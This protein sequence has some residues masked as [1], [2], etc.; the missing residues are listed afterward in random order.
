MEGDLVNAS[1]AR[2]RGS[3]A[4]WDVY[5]PSN[6]LGASTIPAAIGVIVLAAGAAFLYQRIT[7]WMPLIYAN[8]LIAAGLGA[9]IGGL[10]SEAFL[11]THGRSPSMASGLAVAAAVVAFVASFFAG[12]SFLR[13]EIAEGMRELKGKAALEGAV[14]ADDA[15]I[16]AAIQQVGVQDFIEERVESGWTLGR[17][18]SGV[19]ISGV[20][21]WCVWLAELVLIA[22]AA[23]GLAR[24][25][26]D[27][28]YCEDCGRFCTVRH[29]ATLRHM[30]PRAVDDALF[31]ASIDALLAVPSDDRRAPPVEVEAHV[32]RKS[33]PAWL[34]VSTLGRPSERGGKP[35]KLPLLEHVGVPSAVLARVVERA[36]QKAE[37]GG[38]PQAPVRSRRPKPPDV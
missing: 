35:E 8:F 11:R 36:A 30:A 4:E 29:V 17:S 7:T 23:Y 38:A 20:L 10:M 15:A 25:R 37:T 2:S 28:V 34:D 33:C 18:R 5:Q 9:G 24:A 21:V 26:M 14:V 12:A 22:G 27:R 32:C 31:T 19:P 3:R 16:E 1:A 6:R 13:S